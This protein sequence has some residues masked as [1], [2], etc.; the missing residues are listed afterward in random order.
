MFRGVFPDVVAGEAVLHT[1][2]RTSIQVFFVEV[3][4][5]EPLVLGQERLLL[6]LR[7]AVFAG[8]LCLGGLENSASISITLLLVRFLR[9]LRCLDRGFQLQTAGCIFPNVLT[10]E[11]VPGKV[12]RALQLVDSRLGLALFRFVF[13]REQGFVFLG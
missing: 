6:F 9:S 2:A 5:S 13:I 12:I 8:F 3:L 11:V 10:G 4:V 1:R 7:L